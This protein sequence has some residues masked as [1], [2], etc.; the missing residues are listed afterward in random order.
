MY[1]LPS[2][3]PPDRSI[4]PFGSENFAKRLPPVNSLEFVYV[5]VRLT[6]AQRLSMCT[7]YKKWAILPR[8]FSSASLYGREIFRPDK[9]PS[10]E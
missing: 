3:S 5:D 4:L 9:A 8:D 7:F 2:L 1:F 10:D 6:A